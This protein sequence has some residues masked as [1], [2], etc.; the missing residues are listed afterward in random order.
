MVGLAKWVGQAVG[1]GWPQQGVGQMALVARQDVEQV[2]WLY[3]AK[4]VG[5]REE[6]PQQWVMAL[7]GQPQ[8]RR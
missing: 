6:K 4:W 7:Q 1:L 8:E 3:L 5:V 2:V